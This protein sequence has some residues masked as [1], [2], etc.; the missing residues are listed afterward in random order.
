MRSFGS[1]FRL[2]LILVPC[3]L[4]GKIQKGTLRLGHAE[5]EQPWQ[6]LGKFGYGIGSGDYSLRARVANHDFLESTTHLDFDLFLDEDWTGV[7]SL[8]ACQ[9]AVH[10]PSR[11]TLNIDLPATGEWGWWWRGSVIQVVR[12]HIWYFALSSCNQRYS[13]NNTLIIDYEIHFQ[14]GDGS[15]FS[16]EMRYMLFANA[17][18]VLIVSAFLWQYGVWFRSFRQSTGSVHA[19]IWILTGSVAL[20]YAG[21][22]LRA[23]H[24]YKF[25]HDGVGFQHFDLLSEI[26]LM[27]SQVMQCILLIVIALGYTITHSTLDKLELV[28]PLSFAMSIVHAVLVGISKLHGGTSLKNH[29]NDDV[30]GWLLLAFRLV[31]CAWFLLATQAAQEKG[32]FQLQSFLSQFQIAGSVYFLAYPLM[33]LVVQVCAPYLQHPIMQTGLLAMQ[34]A[35][36]GWFA[37]LFLTRGAYFKTSVLSLP[38]LPGCTGLR[39]NKDFH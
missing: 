2:V 16:F 38:L 6:Y 14:Q 18:A 22:I 26:L 4:E 12:P 23:A 9:R 20:Q 30:I 36:N 1:V 13:Q 28:K 3:L 37:S 11:R 35:C 32:C 34:T 8:P 39:L 5:P 21:Q 19:V 29:E 7:E 15:E 10:G 33:F 27:V 31:L 17:A 25:G 24:L